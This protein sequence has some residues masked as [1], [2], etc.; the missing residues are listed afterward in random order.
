[1]NG[2]KADSSDEHARVDFVDCHTKDAALDSAHEA[3]L[4]SESLETVVGDC[5]SAGH[6][7]NHHSGVGLRG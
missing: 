4:A 1:V 7:Q 2:E 6:A 5:S 3:T